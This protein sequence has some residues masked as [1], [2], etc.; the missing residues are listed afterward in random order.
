MYVL[1]SRGSTLT[2]AGDA[3]RANTGHIRIASP[4]VPSVEHCGYVIWDLHCQATSEVVPHLLEIS[5]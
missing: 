1:T 5:F 4:E 3:I 2:K